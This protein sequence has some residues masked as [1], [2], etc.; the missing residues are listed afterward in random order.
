MNKI[1]LKMGSM[2]EKTHTEFKNRVP[3]DNKI[4]E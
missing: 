4:F 3:F 2:D 1:L